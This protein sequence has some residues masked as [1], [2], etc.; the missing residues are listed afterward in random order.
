MREGPEIRRLGAADLR[1]YKALR[2]EMLEA[3]PEAFTSDAF[4]ERHRRADDYLPR[5]GLD[6]P[7]VGHVLLGAWDSGGLTGAIG[8]ERDRRLKVRHI[9]HLVGM[10]VRER[11][12]KLGIGGA[13]LDALLAEGRAAALELLTL[14][15][16]EGNDSAIRLYERAGFVRFGLLQKAIKVGERYHAKVY[17]AKT[18]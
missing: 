9:G 10:M 15:V 4:T 3:H 13:L 16:T 17:M 6:Q 14:T 7:D 12:R 2:D 5:L 18:L 8:L 11:S 1:A